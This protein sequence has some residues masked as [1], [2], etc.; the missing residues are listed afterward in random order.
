MTY[1]DCPGLRPYWGRGGLDTLINSPIKITSQE[2]RIFP[3]KR[4]RV[5]AKEWDIV[6]DTT[7]PSPCW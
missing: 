6:L 2:G 1:A 4:F 5:L 7:I 3:Q